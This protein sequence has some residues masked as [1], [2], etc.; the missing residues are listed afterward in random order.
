[1]RRRLLKLLL[2]IQTS[3]TDI[4]LYTTGMDETDYIKNQ[5][6][7]RA[8]EREFEIIGEALRR[9]SASFPEVAA[10]ITGASQI[11][12]F[13]NVLA[14]GYDVVEDTIVWS[15]LQKRLP[16]L[17]VEVQTLTAEEQARQ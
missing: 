16:T 7:R 9:I 4:Q 11:I 13:R 1:M 17:L 5:V 15:I 12:S 14:H 2:D 3:A 6:V 10:R 8:V